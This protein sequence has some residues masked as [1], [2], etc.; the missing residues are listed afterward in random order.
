MLRAGWSRQSRV[1][2]SF[3][4]KSS[5]GRLK[6]NSL[7]QTDGQTYI[8]TCDESSSRGKNGTCQ[9]KIQQMHTSNLSDCRQTEASESLTDVPLVAQFHGF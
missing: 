9:L 6:N 7:E 2:A 5:V 8:H 4:T 1:A 3:Q